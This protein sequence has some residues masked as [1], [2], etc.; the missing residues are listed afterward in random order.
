MSGFVYAITRKRIRHLKNQ[1]MGVLDIGS[2]E[3]ETSE[4][5]IKSPKNNWKK[6]NLDI[7]YLMI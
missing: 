1:R 7:K 2:R 3:T 6:K 5:E 4:V